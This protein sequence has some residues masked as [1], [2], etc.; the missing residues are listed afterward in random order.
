MLDNNDGITVID[1][2]DPEAPAYCFVSICGLSKSDDTSNIKNMTSLSA[3][4]YLRSYYPKIKM[5][6]SETLDQREIMFEQ[7]ILTTLRPFE[8]V[9]MITI[10]MLAEA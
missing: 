3:T 4:R 5:D 10:D 6:D 2:T 9:H 8:S 1:V 7:S